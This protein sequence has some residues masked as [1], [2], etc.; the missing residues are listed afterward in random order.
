MSI[1]TRNL[2]M[3]QRDYNATAA[4]APGLILNFRRMWYKELA[5]VW[6]QSNPLCVYLIRDLSQWY[7]ISEDVHHNS[8]TASFRDLNWCY[9]LLIPPAVFQ[10]I[11]IASWSMLMYWTTTHRVMDS[12][13][14]HAS[15]MFQ[16]Q[17]HPI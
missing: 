4:A 17:V 10:L 1:L 15:F 5:S 14:A 13:P 6:H 8:L 11:N 9:D 2:Y 3:L 16:R 7:I 12:N